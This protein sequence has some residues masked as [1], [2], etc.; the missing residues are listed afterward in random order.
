MRYAGEDA[1]RVRPSQSQKL[2]PIQHPV[3]P[4]K[5]GAFAVSRLID[6]RIILVIVR[7]YM[8]WIEYLLCDESLPLM[9]EVHRR[10]REKDGASIARNES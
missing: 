4:H 9:L 1:Y 10:V 3:V 2:A 7:I 6:P 5:L 8:S